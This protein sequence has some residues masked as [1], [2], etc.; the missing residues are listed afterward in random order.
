MSYGD[1]SWV[2]RVFH[3]KYEKT[4]PNTHYRICTNPKCGKI[5]LEEQ[6]LDWKHPT[7]A[8]FCP[9]CYEVTEEISKDDIEIMTCPVCNGRGTTDAWWTGNNDCSNCDGNSYVIR[10]TQK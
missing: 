5:V 8:R 10:E 1:V 2:Q 7:G 9:K 6:C 4:R 3:K